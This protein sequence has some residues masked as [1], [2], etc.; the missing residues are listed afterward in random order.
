MV[1]TLVL[2][3][4]GFALG[5]VSR[6]EEA[7]DAVAGI[8]IG[9]CITVIAWLFRASD[10][11]VG[12]GA[13]ADAAPGSTAQS[14][15][16]AVDSDDERAVLRL[17]AEHAGEVTIAGVAMQTELSLDDAR[18]LLEGLHDRGFCERTRTEQ[19]ATIYRFPDLV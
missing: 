7:V 16:S 2:G 9:L 5:S 4:V 11:A 3:G 19:G 12:N 1:S 10:G 18:D 15:P 6:G 14:A 13:V 17:A 8:V